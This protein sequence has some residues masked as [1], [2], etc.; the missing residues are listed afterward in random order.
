MYHSLV[1]HAVKNS[2]KKKKKFI[3]LKT[4]T[5]MTALSEVSKDDRPF[6]FSLLCPLAL[7]RKWF[8]FQSVPGAM[9]EPLQQERAAILNVCFFFP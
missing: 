1:R 4:M 7:L 9:I 5:I 6:H 2:D 8:S 3:Y